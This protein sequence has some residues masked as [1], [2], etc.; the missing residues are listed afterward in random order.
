VSLDGASWNDRQAKKE[1]Y[2]HGDKNISSTA[3]EMT[4]LNRYT[5]KHAQRTVVDGT[6]GGRCIFIM[7]PEAIASTNSPIAFNNACGS[8][9]RLAGSS[10]LAV[11][12]CYFVTLFRVMDAEAQ[13]VLDLRC[14]T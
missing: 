6:S 3:P 14:S 8:S 13:Q 4:H 11:P 5:E 1:L 2:V 12:R 7:L 9:H 10:C